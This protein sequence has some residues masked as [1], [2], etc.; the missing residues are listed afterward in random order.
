MSFK[1]SLIPAVVALGFAATASAQSTVQ[2]YGVV[3][4]T[5]G[6]YQ[7]SGTQ[8][9][10]DNSRLTKVDGNQMVTSYLG[11]KGVEDLGDGL[12]AGFVLESF[13]RPDTGASGR[14]DASVGKT[15]ADTFWSRAANVYLQGG[16]GKVTLGRQI[17]LPYLQTVQFNPFGG[18]FGLAPAVRLTYG[19]WG[20]DRAD[21]GWSNAISYTSPNLSGFT[22]T[23]LAETGEQADKSERP[24]YA[25]AVNYTSGPLALAAS[26][27]TVG[28]AEAP[29]LDLTKGQRQTFGLINASYDAGVAKFFGEY[30]QIENHG[31]TGANGMHTSLYQVG[32]S[33][34]VTAAGKVLA[35][36][37]ASKEK[38]AHGGTAKS[39]MHSIFTVAYDYNL[40]KRTDVYAAIM[41]DDEKQSGYKNGESYVLGLRHAF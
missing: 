24:S 11:F 31:Y 23:V 37:G 9:S 14:N 19:K 33:V 34:P 35:S 18:S 2:V 26:W 6:S 27:Q 39:V 4:L 22:A 16:F 25:M 36:Y 38:A 40:S 30:G 15:Q 12:K 8:G 7:Y 17:A 13:M 20:N 21:S 3:D 41:L 1:K 5:L 29:K 10:A 32:A 28:S